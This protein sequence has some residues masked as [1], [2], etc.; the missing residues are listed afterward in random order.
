MIPTLRWLLGVTASAVI[1][2]L[3]LR[4]FDKS[5]MIA[6]L[7]LGAPLLVWITGA[8]VLS[9]KES[10]RAKKVAEIREAIHSLGPG[11]LGYLIEGVCNSDGHTRRAVAHVLPD[12]VRRMRMGAR[13]ELS[14]RQRELLYASLGDSIVRP[15]EYPAELLL[16]LIRVV[17]HDS[18][19]EAV[20]HL[21]DLRHHARA[22]EVRQAAQDCIDDLHARL[23]QQHESQT[24]LRPGTPEQ[25]LLHPAGPPPPEPDPL[26]LRPIDPGSA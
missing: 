19:P 8:I 10:L 17:G 22:A 1:I 18:D 4:F 24:L 15:N 2:A 26:L 13:P 11:A 21:E 9:T 3:V 14:H 6:F 16:A 5:P 23:S 12:Y 7:L 20:P 25:P